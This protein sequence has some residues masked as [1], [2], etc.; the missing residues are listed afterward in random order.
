MHPSVVPVHLNETFPCN[1]IV[2]HSGFVSAGE[3]AFRAMIVP[4]EVF[5][6]EHCDKEGL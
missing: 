1:G 3:I 2:Y 5:L 4:R 6:E